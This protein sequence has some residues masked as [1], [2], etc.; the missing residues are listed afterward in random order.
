MWYARGAFARRADAP[1]LA[2]QVV[3]RLAMRHRRTGP[4]L[5]RGLPARELHRQRRPTA[6]AGKAGLIAE[7]MTPVR[8][9]TSANTQEAE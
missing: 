9:C 7:C 8:Y 3:A 6:L 1:E 5:A 2:Q 4:R